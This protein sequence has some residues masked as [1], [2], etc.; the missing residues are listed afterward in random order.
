MPTTF[1]FD[2]AMAEMK[3]R[4]PDLRDKPD[5]EV[6]E[7]LARE[8]GSVAP[9]TKNDLIIRTGAADSTRKYK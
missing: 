5:A 8:Y 7:I 6:I 9:T 3:R 2:V 4:R 1:I